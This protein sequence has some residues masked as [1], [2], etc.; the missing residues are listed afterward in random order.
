MFL[1]EILSS[2][3][4]DV[5]TIS[6]QATLA[7]VVQQLNGH[8]CGLLVVSDGQEMVGVISERDILRAMADL[9]TPLEEIPVESHM[10]SNV[11]TGSP[12]DDVNSMM[13]QMTKNRIRHLPVMDNEKLVGVIS[14]GDLVKAHI[15]KLTMENHLLMNYIQS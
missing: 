11:I 15:D 10:T 7:E 14:I 3:G 12:S 5:F 8:R 1:K 9:D 13:G 6:P 4:D 2:K